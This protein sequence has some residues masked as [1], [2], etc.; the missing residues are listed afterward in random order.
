MSFFLHRSLLCLAC[1]WSQAALCLL[2]L[3]SKP[4]L[5]SSLSDLDLSDMILLYTAVYTC[6]VA[7]NV[8]FAVGAVP[9]PTVPAFALSHFVDFW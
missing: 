4:L 6:S 7:I 2:Y 8:L 3:R 5:H 1:L 9:V